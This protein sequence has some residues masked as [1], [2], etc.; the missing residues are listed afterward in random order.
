MGKNK[1][2]M[3]HKAHMPVY[4]WSRI[5]LRTG[6]S[7]RGSTRGSRGPKNETSQTIG[8]IVDAGGVPKWFRQWKSPVFEICE[9]HLMKIHK[10]KLV[11]LS[12]QVE[13]PNGLDNV[14]EHLRT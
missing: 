5:F 1:Q 11:T 14:K 2:K 10:Q 3:I 12:K 6:G 13:Q 4:K 7:T 8:G 9:L